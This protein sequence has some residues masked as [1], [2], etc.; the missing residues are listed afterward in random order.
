MSKGSGVGVLDK[1]VG[2]LDALSEGPLSLSALVKHSGLTRATAYRLACALA[3]HDLISV[4][5][6]G[7]FTLGPH[8]R[9]LGRQV[10]EEPLPRRSLPVLERLQRVTGESTQLYQRRGR[11][12]V[13]LVAVDPP[14]GLRDSVPVGAR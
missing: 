6:G 12:R 9:A 3:V 14:S 7:R 13:C 2:I 5:P 10:V 1:V 11:E 8:L 4:D